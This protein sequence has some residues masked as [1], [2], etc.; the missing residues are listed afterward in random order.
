MLNNKKLYLKRTVVLGVSVL[1]LFLVVILIDVT[2]KV[3]AA[4]S[5]SDSEL[6]KLQDSLASATANRK[7]AQKAYNAAKD[8][9]AGLIEQK[10]VLDEEILA[11][12]S[13]YEAIE[14]LIAEYEVQLDRLE[15]DI[16]NTEYELDGMM[17]TLK[18]R[19]RLSY[20]DGFGSYINIVFESENLTEFL[21]Q[22]EWV[23]YL[24][25][26]DK[27]LINDCS[28]YQKKLSDEEDK[29]I[30]LQSEAQEQ[31]KALEESKA[32]AESKR[33]EV[34]A[35]MAT[36]DE[37]IESAK[38]LYQKYY[39]NEQAFDK[40]IEA[41]IEERQKQNQ[42]TYV[43]GDFIWPLPR[44]DKYVTSPF[45]Y[46]VHPITGAYEFH[47]GIDISS[48]LGTNIY[49]VNSGVVAEASFSSGNGNYVLIDHGGGT[50][51]YYSHL[52][53]ILVKKDQQ[54]KQ[55]EVIGLV[56]MTGLATGYHLHFS[57]YQNGKA[58]DPLGFYDT[59]WMIMYY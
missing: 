14:E 15:G 52:S 21:T 42:T 7:E 54:V 31:V 30:R 29:V 51:S 26:Y 57:M 27:T 25:N 41:L 17:N 34:E 32:L 38:E 9:K 59:S 11:I 53:K 2:G 49:S 23:S 37:D 56:G 35:L 36:V 24:I 6:Q 13:E 46:R 3:S 22:L 33:T 12:Q 1:L 20:E 18:D 45:G 8:K 39:E 47:T 19:L 50:M 55:G 44:S 58:V 4:S 16:D 48:H 5:S 40:K 10:A 43:G 28:E